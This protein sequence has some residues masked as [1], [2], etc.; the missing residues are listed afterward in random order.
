M[1]SLNRRSRAT[2]VGMATVLIAAI[3]AIGAPSSLAAQVRPDS[4]RVPVSPPVKRGEQPSAE[5]MQQQ[6]D[7]V[8]PMMSQ[9][10]QAMLQ[11]ALAVLA[12]PESAERMATFTRNYFDALVAKGFSREDALRIV[13]AHGIPTLPAGR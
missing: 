8:T 13:M 3:V 10:S 12:Q 4:V 9:M 2:S 11:G 1:E 6:M 7:M 5:V